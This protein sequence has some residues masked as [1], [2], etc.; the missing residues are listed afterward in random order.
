[1]LRAVRAVVGVVRGCSLSFEF[2]FRRLQN[3]FTFQT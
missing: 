1:M 2:V 3:G